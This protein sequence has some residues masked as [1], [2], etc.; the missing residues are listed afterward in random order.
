M[1]EIRDFSGKLFLSKPID[2]RTFAEKIRRY[3]EEKS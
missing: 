1:E 3:I 2:T